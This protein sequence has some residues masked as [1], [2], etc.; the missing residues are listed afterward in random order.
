[1]EY[2]QILAYAIQGIRFAMT[3][4]TAGSQA[5]TILGQTDAA[6]TAMQADGNRAPTQAER[7]ALQATLD[8]LAA[9]VAPAE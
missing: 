2:A 1:M 4:L 8:G 5:H 3:T 9:R 6:L 7:D